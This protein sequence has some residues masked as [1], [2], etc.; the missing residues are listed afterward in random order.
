MLTTSF[1]LLHKAGACEERYRHLAKALGGIKKYGRATP[2]PLWRGLDTNGLD[3]T[4]WALRAVMPGQEAEREKLARL[5]ACWCARQVW[6]LLTD[7]RS[8]TAVEV[9]ERYAVG[10]ATDEELDAAGVAPWD[11]A[12]VAQTAH[13][14]KMLGGDDE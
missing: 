3:D 5:F 13:L 9:A 14:R 7:E 8:R 6:H 1:E 10:E 11:A 4:L 12:G 2:I